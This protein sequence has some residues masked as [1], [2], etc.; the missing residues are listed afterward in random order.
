[1]DVTATFKSFSFISRTM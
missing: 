1:M